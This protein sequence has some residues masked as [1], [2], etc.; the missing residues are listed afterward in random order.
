M[1]TVDEVLKSISSDNSDG[2]QVYNR[3]SKKNFNMLLEAMM[4]DTNFKESIVKKANKDTYELEDVMVTKEFRKW[5]KKIVEKLGVDS[6]ESKIVLT[7]E[8]VIDNVSGLY[9]FFTAVIYEYMIAGNRFEIPAHE[10]FKGSIYLKDIDEK[11][12]VTD[13]KNPRDGSFLGR[14]ETKTKKHKTLAV[15]SS[16][17]TYLSEKRKIK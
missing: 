5:L 9:E 4:N 16:C 12:K 11:V 1:S 17:P 2:K 13:C 3:F 10:D 8:F 14:Y 7:D 15:K 6:N